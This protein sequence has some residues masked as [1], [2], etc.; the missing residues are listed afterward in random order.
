[1][2]LTSNA[3]RDFIPAAAGEEEEVGGGQALRHTMLV[4]VDT[5]GGSFITVSDDNF[6]G[7]LALSLAIQERE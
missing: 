1:M 3:R 6:L 4:T 2:L 7:K 5:G